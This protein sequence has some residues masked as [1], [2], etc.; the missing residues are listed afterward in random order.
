MLQIIEQT[1]EEKIKMYLKVPKLKLIEMLLENQRMV[2]EFR[3]K[4]I[5]DVYFPVELGT[6]I[7]FSN[8]QS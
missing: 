7:F 5:N 8:K 3:P 6:E 1:R 4:G 2:E